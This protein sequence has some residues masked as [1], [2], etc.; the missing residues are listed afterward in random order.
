MDGLHP[1][2]SWLAEPVALSSRVT[3]L[4]AVTVGNGTGGVV[5]NGNGATGTLT[6]ASLAFTGAA[7][8]NPRVISSSTAGINVTGTLSTSPING[9]ITVNPAGTF[10]AGMN[11]LVTA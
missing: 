9:T 5:A 7:T 11:N 3:T 6:L 4:G 10:A 8:I 2:G 1:T